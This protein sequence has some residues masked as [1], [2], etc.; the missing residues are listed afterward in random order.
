MPASSTCSPSTSPRTG[1]TRTGGARYGGCWRAAALSGLGLPSADVA[2]RSLFTPGC[3]TGRLSERRELL[4]ASALGAAA[5]GARA[6]LRAL[7]APA[8]P[9]ASEVSS[10]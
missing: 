9:R 3:G 6:A 7:A 2:A 5:G 4:V 1:S 10:P 8:H